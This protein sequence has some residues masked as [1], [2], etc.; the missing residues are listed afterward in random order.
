MGFFCF[1]TTDAASGD[2][3]PNILFLSID[4]LR[5]SLG[6]YGDTLAKTPAID[7]FA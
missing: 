2:T 5:P 7:R 3:P 4:D 1:A 6:C